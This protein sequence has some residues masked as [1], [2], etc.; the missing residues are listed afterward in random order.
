MNFI[1]NL[2]AA[3]KLPPHLSVDTLIDE[4]ETYQQSYKC[5][6]ETA[7]DDVIDAYNEG[8]ADDAD[9]RRNGDWD[10]GRE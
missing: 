10:Y 7:I 6:L 8:A 2:I 1:R 5:D 3:K 4:A 9:A